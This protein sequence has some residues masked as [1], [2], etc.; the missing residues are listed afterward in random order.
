MENLEET[1][2]GIDYKIIAFNRDGEWSH[3]FATADKQVAVRY[4][5][6]QVTE[7]CRSVKFFEGNVEV[8]LPPDN[9]YAQGEFIWSD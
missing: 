8:A 3:T 9:G 6:A 1:T 5:N 2:I 7:S 4:G